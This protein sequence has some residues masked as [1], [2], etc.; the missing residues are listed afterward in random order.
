MRNILYRRPLSDD[1]QVPLM[2][3]ILREIRNTQA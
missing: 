3:R 1:Q 2:T